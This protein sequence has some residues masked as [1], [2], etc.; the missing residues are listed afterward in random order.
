MSVYRNRK[1]GTWSYDFWWDG[2]RIKE[3]TRQKS[4][5]VARQMEAARKTDLARGEAGIQRRRCPEFRRFV[6]TEFLPW[7]EA[8]HRGRAG[9]TYRRHLVSCRPLLEFFSGCL[10]S[11]I[12]SGAVEKYKQRRASEISS[13]T[14]RRLRPATVNR[15]LAALRA[16]FG[17]A[18]KQGL[19]KV[20]PVHGLRFLPEDNEQ[21]RVV[22]FEEQGRYFRAAVLRLREVATLILN[23]GMRPEEV[24]RLKRED[25]HLAE[26]YLRVPFGKTR[27]ARRTI[28]LNREARVLL[29]SRLGKLGTGVY[30]FPSKREPGRPMGLVSNTHARTVKRAGLAPFR[31]YDLRHTFATR[32]VQSGMDLPTLAKILGHSKINMVLRYAHPTPEHERLAM[33]KMERYVE[34]NRPQS[35][36]QSH[37]RGAWVQ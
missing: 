26:G 11:E 23:T 31:L 6:E 12:D 36:S 13:A 20:N 37:S 30:V 29:A 9:Q 25:V 22:S 1:S 3:S 18:V 10:L 33:S 28:P 4:K 24:Y 14:G 27:A 8:T 2:H 5:P 32:A 34:K 19:V 7:F 21:T 35:H 15:D 16:I 17:L